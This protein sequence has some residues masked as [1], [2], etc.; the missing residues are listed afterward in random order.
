[1]A[2]QQILPVLVLLQSDGVATTFVYSLSRLSQMGVSPCSKRADWNLSTIPSAAVLNPASL[3]T[4]TID[5]REHKI[6]LNV[7][8]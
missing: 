5:G 1:M 3:G 7:F 2:L 8:S 4:A 6:T